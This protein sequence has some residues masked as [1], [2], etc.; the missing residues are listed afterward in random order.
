ML[1][2]RYGARTLPRRESYLW[3]RHS[4][5]PGPRPPAP[6]LPLAAIRLSPAPRMLPRR[7]S[8]TPRLSP[9]APGQPLLRTYPTRSDHPATAGPARGWDEFPARVCRASGG[10]VAPALRGAARRPRH[11]LGGEDID[12]ISRLIHFSNHSGE[13]HHITDFRGCGFVS[14]RPSPRLERGRRTRGT[15]RNPWEWTRMVPPCFAR[16]GAAALA[17]S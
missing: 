9:G 15:G 10:W 14:P 4:A 17:S 16:P 8:R 1:S 5:Y 6:G 12:L 13:T 3:R 7:H 2:R 11:N